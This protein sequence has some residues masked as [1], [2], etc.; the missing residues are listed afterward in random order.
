MEEVLAQQRNASKPVTGSAFLRGVALV[1]IK[2]AAAQVFVNLAIALSG[3]GLLNIAFYLYAVGLMVSFM[4]RTVAGSAYVLRPGTL[5]LSKMLGDSTTSVV[6]IP[7]KDILSVRPVMLGERLECSVRRVTVIDVRAVQGARM[8]L[9]YGMALFSARLARRIAA[10]RESRLRGYAVVYMEEGKRQACV[11]LPDEAFLAALTALLPG[12]VGHD[13]RETGN[14]TVMARALERAFP[15]LYPFVNPLL[16]EE[17][18]RQAVEAIA[19]QKAQKKAR[20]EA[21][22][23][24]WRRGKRKGAKAGEKHDGKDGTV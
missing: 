21:R 23:N 20:R 12:K 18:R 4:G 7:T 9:A 5:S 6:E 2:L 19:A 13:E 11:F 24:W 10:H 3:V 22:I 16:S 1:L 14:E 8:R 15:E 17:R